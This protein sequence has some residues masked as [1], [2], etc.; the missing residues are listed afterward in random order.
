MRKLLLIVLSLN[1]SF[2]IA[3]PALSPEISSIINYQG[4]ELPEKA[5]AHG[6]MLD[7]ARQKANGETGKIVGN[8]FTRQG[9]Y[10][11]SHKDKTASRKVVNRSSLK[12]K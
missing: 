11:I 6:D 9:E 5:Y 3:Q 1:P 8:S 2:V 12:K 7:A 4:T 10:K